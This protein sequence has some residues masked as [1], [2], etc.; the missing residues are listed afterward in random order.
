MSL[1]RNI[2]LWKIF[3]SALF[4][5]GI[6]TG[7]NSIVTLY[8]R[9]MLG[10]VVIGLCVVALVSMR[11]A[12]AQ[13]PALKCLSVNTSG[14]VQLTWQPP[15]D[16]CG[17]FSNYYIYFAPVASGPYVLIDSVFNF[18]TT[19]YTHTGAGA[20]LNA[21]FYFVSAN[22]GCISAI[23]DTLQSIFLSVGNTAGGSTN[24]SWNLLHTPSVPTSTDMIRI[25]REDG[26][27]VL[28]IIDSAFQIS[29]YADPF[30]TCTDSIDYQ[31]MV[32]DSS[33]CVSR[34]NIAILEPDDIPPAQVFIDSVSVD[35]LT[36]FATIGWQAS[37]SLDVIRYIIFV[38]NPFGGW[39]SVG[40]S[41]GIN[42]TFFL[43]IASFPDTLSALYDVIAVDACGNKSLST[44]G[45]SLM[46]LIDTLDT[47][48]GEVL[49]EWTPY[50][51]WPTGGASYDVFI[52]EDGGA[53][54]LDT[55]VTDT[56][57]E[58]KGIKRGVT[59]CY[60]IRAKELNGPNTSSTSIICG[61]GLSTDTADQASLVL[62]V[63]AQDSVKNLLTWNEIP[64][65][66][67]L[68]ATYDIYRSFDDGP[69]V[70]IA[71][72]SFDT[73]FYVDF[74]DPLSAFIEGE[75]NFSYYVIPVKSDPNL[76]GC[77]N[78]SN[79]ASV[80]QFP[81]YVVANTF[82]PNGDGRNDVFLPI[83][84]FIQ[85]EDYLL[86]IYNR[87]GQKIFETTDITQGWDGTNN[88][89]VAQNDAYVYFVNFKIRGGVPIQKAGTVLL[90]R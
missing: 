86:I 48:K 6:L 82:T 46:M 22:S 55:S 61:F 31:I 80:E 68:V 34:S 14:N 73:T 78:I 77:L 30:T 26:L 51:S 41:I 21:A 33:G 70:L 71:S 29:T 42:N 50:T 81:R 16:S 7:R 1:Q 69:F 12:N 74:L 24:M 66:A 28:A 76:Y 45:H 47:C 62:E 59:Y 2:D 19:T 23:S 9:G 15:L 67:G 18:N 90:L 63:E 87:W 36:G 58:Q 25:F 49:L 56:Y 52:S 8:F 44:L 17:V 35:P 37:T 32:S 57:Y 89:F 65:W 27:G 64:E 60:F 43:D 39:D 13:A 4:V 38:A 84:V 10:R 53:F 3:T 88:G 72:V 54:I 20:D 85:T 5:S 75:G 40:G 11:P 79:V 83:R